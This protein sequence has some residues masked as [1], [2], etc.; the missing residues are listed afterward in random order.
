MSYCLPTYIPERLK[1][2]GLDCRESKLPRNKFTKVHNFIKMELNNFMRMFLK[3]ILNSKRNPVLK[4]DKMNK[5][6]LSKP[7]RELFCA[8]KKTS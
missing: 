5:N 1:I 3:V 6:S 2:I 8:F 7:L 4:Q